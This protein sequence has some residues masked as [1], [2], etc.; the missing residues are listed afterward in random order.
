[1]KQ[2][3]EETLFSL[4]AEEVSFDPI[5]DRLRATIEA[6]FEEELADFRGRL[7]YRRGGGLAVTVQ[8]AKCPA[9]PEQAAAGWYVL[10]G[11]RIFCTRWKSRSTCR[12]RSFRNCRLTICGCIS[13]RRSLS[14]ASGSLL[15]RP[16]ALLTVRLPSGMGGC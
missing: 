7:R 6:V 5:E 14:Q 2:T 12:P 8:F 4:L 9:G 15:N 1:M 11:S 10:R 13:T 16:D 3:I